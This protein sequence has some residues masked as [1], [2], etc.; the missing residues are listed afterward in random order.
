MH[1]LNY[2]VH[3]RREDARGVCWPSG[4]PSV[5]WTV[6]NDEGDD[7]LSKAQLKS[8]PSGELGPDSVKTKHSRT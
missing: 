3:E 1:A 4:S 8:K 6:G 7:A 5:R 2:C